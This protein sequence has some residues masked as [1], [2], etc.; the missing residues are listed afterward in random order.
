MV[1]LRCNNCKRVFQYSGDEKFYTACPQCNAQVPIARPRNY[2]TNNPE[3]FKG[4][5]KPSFK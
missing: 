4:K 1:E 3:I 2:G 5:R